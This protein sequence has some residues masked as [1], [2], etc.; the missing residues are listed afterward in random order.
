MLNTQSAVVYASV[1]CPAR[2]YFPAVEPVP[3]ATALVRGVCR[4][5][6]AFALWAGTRLVRGGQNDKVP[7]LC[8]PTLA[9]AAYAFYK[10]ITPQ[11]TIALIVGQARWTASHPSFLP[12]GLVIV[13]DCC[14]C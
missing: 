6:A 12:S 10:D 4:Y 14:A 11:F 9:A 2:R 3:G 8:V 5:V 1:G 7:V 13:V